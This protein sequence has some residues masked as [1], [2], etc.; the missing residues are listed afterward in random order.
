MTNAFVMYLQMVKCRLQCMS[1]KIFEVDVEIIKKSVIIKS[2]LEGKF[3]LVFVML[4]NIQELYKLSYIVYC[5][6]AASL[7]F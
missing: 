4:C 2:M 7:C 3:S 6:I 5:H 1:G